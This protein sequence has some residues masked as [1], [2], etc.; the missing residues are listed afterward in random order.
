MEDSEFWS[1][2]EDESE[3]E[4]GWSFSPEPM[5]RAPSAEQAQEMAQNH[6]ELSG[7]G[8]QFHTP[9]S[10]SSPFSNS[11]NMT[12]TTPSRLSGN[13]TRRKRPISEKENVTQDPVLEILSEVKKTNTRL[14]SYDKKMAAF[15]ERLKSFE[16]MQ[17][18]QTP[19]SSD[20]ASQIKR[21]VP[22]QIR[23]G[24][25]VGRPTLQEVKGWVSRQV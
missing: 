1:S 23:V 16:D 25:C 6:D 7:H 17:R 9:T 10:R 4:N 13:M 2:S 20:S 22:T 19:S 14:D 21:K 12:S 5:R 8:S 24:V 15:E 18:S 3:D 11:K